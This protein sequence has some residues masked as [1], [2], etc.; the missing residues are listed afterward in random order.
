[1]AT[2]PQFNQYVE[3]VLADYSIHPVALSQQALDVPLTLTA[4]ASGYAH[5]AS[6][7]R[8]V[9]LPLDEVE[10]V[11][12]AVAPVYPEGVAEN[13]VSADA[14]LTVERLLWVTERPQWRAGIDVVAG[15]VYVFQNLLHE[16]VQSHTTE[17]NW[18]PLAARAL[19][20]R[21]YETGEIPAWVQ[22]L[23]GFDAYRLGFKVTHDGFTWESLI[24]ANGFEPGAVGTEALW[25]NLTPPPQPTEW[26]S[27]E[28]GLQVGDLRSYEGVV[29]RLLQNPGI[30]IW[31]PPIVPAIW[32]A[33]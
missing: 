9:A 27:G 26:L 10:A 31:Q 24:D 22:P 6:L 20:K 18:T 25:L 15:E 23:G 30:N 4:L 2:V 8:E 33:V 3:Y 13:E 32:Q 19:F 17:A 12:N 21:Y 7:G 14:A 28:Q 1:M 16:V 29:Y 5:A 11:V